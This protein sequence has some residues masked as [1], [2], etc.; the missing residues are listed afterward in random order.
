MFHEIYGKNF[1]CLFIVPDRGLVE[2]TSQDFID[3]GLPLKVTKWTGDDPLDLTGNIIVANLG[4]L[5]SKNSDLSW[6]EDIDVLFVDEVHKIRKGNEINKLFKHIKTPHRFGLT[7]T[8]PEN[9][10]DQWNIIGKIGPVIFERHSYHL[11]EEKYISGAEIKILNIKHSAKGNL[12]YRE[13]VEE[14]ISNKFRNETI[15]RLSNGLNYNTLIL[16]DYIKHGELLFELLNRECKQK[17]VFFICGDVDISERDKVRQLMETKDNI[18]VIAISKIFS[19]GINI[20]NLHYIVFACGGKAKIKIVQSIGRGLRLH[21]NKD[22]LIIFDIADN[23]HY[24]QKHL[25][26]R[27]SLYEKEQI[28]YVI[29]QITST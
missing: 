22:K 19:T 5:Q 12:S 1:K 13:E 18:V 23:Y 17:K 27:I 20:K 2:Q 11:R 25:H 10:L 26:K 29:N 14:L 28:K 4:I 3:Y 16:V 8:M 21:D 7:G 15:C 9:L 6:T 24:S